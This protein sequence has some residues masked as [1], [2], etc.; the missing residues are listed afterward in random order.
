[1]GSD[2]PKQFLH[3]GGQPILVHSLK[4][5]HAASPE[6]ELVVVLPAAQLKRWATLA[7]EF[8]PGVPHRVV[9][10]G[11]TRFLSVKNGLDLLDP[12]GVVAIH[13]G[14]RPL[15]S[16]TLIRRAFE[17]AEAHG[18]AVPVVPVNE[19]LRKISG[20]DSFA[21]DR[22]LFRIVQTPQVFRTELIREAFGKSDCATFTD[23]ASV[24]ET[25]GFRVFLIDGESRNL[26]ITR[27]DDLAIAQVLI[28][29]PFHL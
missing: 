8:A 18:S 25:T 26:K 24:L 20:E 15:V 23:D 28:S 13:D 21:A 12:D 9:E 14:A 6:A 10:G 5:F 2:I 4:A 3:L 11:E 19:S 17:A 1:M 27:P 22:T 7:R 29:R 16:E